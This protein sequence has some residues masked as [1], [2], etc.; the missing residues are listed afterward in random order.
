MY[1]T[2]IPSR[3]IQKD[4]DCYLFFSG[5]AYLGMHAR[6]EFGA[7]VVQGFE[8]YGTNYGA[9][10]LGNVVIPVFDEAEKKLASWL[11]A[12]HALL[13]SSGTL[14]GRLALEVLGNE[15][16]YHFGTNA[17]IAINPPYMRHDP[18]H[19]GCSIE[20]TLDSL[21]FSDHDRHVIAFNTVDALTASTPSLDWIDRLPKD[22]EIILLIDD[23]HGIGVLGDA[24]RGLYD[25]VR[26]RHQDTVLI[27]SM[28]KAMGLPAGLIAGPVHIIAQIKKHPMF[29]GSSPM[30]PAYAYAYLNADAIYQRAYNELQ[31]NISYFTAMLNKKELFDF[32]PLFPIYCTGQKQ[33]APY[34]DLHKIC[35]SQ[36]SYPSPSDPVYTRLIINA[37]HTKNDLDT[38]LNLLHSF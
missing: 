23:S 16:K 22:K 1:A 31:S 3:I 11:D 15:Y 19:F 8:K 25:A 12:P 2:H 34:L 7:L 29:G 9:S 35:I 5:T 26:S 28:G 20:D 32:I 18:V 4:G 14:A 17:H 27:A 6:P 10:R 38:L 21:Y 24:G 36:F 30:I 13:V 33:L 37:L